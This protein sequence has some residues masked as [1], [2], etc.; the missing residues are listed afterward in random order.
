MTKTKSTDDPHDDVG[1]YL[2]RQMH[3][4][5]MMPSVVVMILNTMRPT[6]TPIRV[7]SSAQHKTALTTS[8]Q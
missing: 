5:I 2:E 8:S 4:V 7:F 1:G 6:V 3:A